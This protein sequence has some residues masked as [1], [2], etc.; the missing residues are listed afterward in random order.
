MKFNIFIAFLLVFF[1]SISLSQQQVAENL[2][3]NAAAINVG[4][5]YFYLGYNR[6]FFGSSSIK[7]HGKNHKF[8]LK[9]VKASDR[10]SI[11]SED[12]YK[13][14]S[15]P[16]YNIRFGYRFAPYWNISIGIDHM[17]YV[18]DKGQTAI[19]E[20]YINAEDSEQYAGNYDN[21][22]I[23]IEKKFFNFRTYGWF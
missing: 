10:A 12:Y 21:E 20:G 16:Q 1:E 14:V 3:T 2:P 11:L 23:V 18:L 8:E 15:V 7:F 13:N 17:K 19:I 6:A 9:D 4:K 22:A 5:Y